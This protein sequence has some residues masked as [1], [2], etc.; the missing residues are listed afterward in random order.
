[1]VAQV[2]DML[3][4]AQESC[5]NRQG[6]RSLYT[7][8]YASTRETSAP[9]KVSRHTI[10]TASPCHCHSPFSAVTAVWPRCRTIDC[11]IPERYVHPLTLLLLIFFSHCYYCSVVPE[12]LR[13]GCTWYILQWPMVRN[14]GSL[15]QEQPIHKDECNVTS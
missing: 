10:C 2:V 11:M 1:M 7:T 4:R 15:L 14:C 6:E 5:F 8:W 9:A 12:A 13:L 3:V